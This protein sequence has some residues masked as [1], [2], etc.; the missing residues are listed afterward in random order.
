MHVGFAGAWAAILVVLGAIAD[1]ALGA[2]IC[3]RRTAPLGLLGALILT[4]AYLAGASIY[5]HDLWA[6][7]L[8]PLVKTVPAAVL[9]VVALAMMDER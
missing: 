5:R 2:L 3:A 8:G 6:D 4:M 1:L 7:P 9:A